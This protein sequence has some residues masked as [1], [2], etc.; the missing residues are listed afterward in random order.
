[1]NRTAAARRLARLEQAVRRR[2]VHRVRQ[3]AE[4]AT[5]D[6]PGS[7]REALAAHGVDVVAELAKI[8]ADWRTP[9]AMRARILRT[10]AQ[11]GWPRFASVEVASEQDHRFVVEA[12]DWSPAA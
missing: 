4:V 8:A 5:S 10:L 3:L 7:L 11:Y 12:P 2:E 9:D 6:A 1:M